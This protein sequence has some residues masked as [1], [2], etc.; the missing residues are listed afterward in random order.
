MGASRASSA[1]DLG[2]AARRTTSPV[3]LVELA[4]GQVLREEA[5]VEA[6][7]TIL[8]LLATLFGCCAAL[9]FQQDAG[10]QE[11]GHALVVLATHPSQAAADEVLLAEIRAL[12]AQ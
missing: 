11:D 8:G 10:Q 12:A 5:A 9:A 2:A 7:P 1:A 4:V 3:E 6:L